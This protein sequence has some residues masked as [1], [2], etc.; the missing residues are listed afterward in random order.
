VKYTLDTDIFIDAFRDALPRLNS[1]GFLERAL[2]F[3]FLSAN[4]AS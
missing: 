3:T 2:P 1:L 4:P